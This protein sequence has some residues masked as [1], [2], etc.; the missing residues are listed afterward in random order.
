MVDRALVLGVKRITLFYP[1][2]DILLKIDNKTRTQALNLCV[3]L[4]NYAYNKGLVVDFATEDA[5]RADFDFLVEVGQALSCFVDTFLICYTVGCLQPNWSHKLVKDFIHATGCK[6]GVHYHNDLGLALQNT[7]QGIFA[8]ARVVSGTFTGI[9]ERAGNAALEEVL[10]MLKQEHNIVVNGIDY[11]KVAEVCFLIKKVFR[12]KPAR[13]LS[14]ASFFTETGI[15]VH[16]LLKDTK[17]YILFPH[18]QPIIW[19]GKY[20][21]ASNFKWLFEREIKKQPL[22]RR[23][24]QAHARSD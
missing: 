7:I 1:V 15:H 14:R 19:F 4:C 9:G 23:T 5:T 16:R 17:S 21:G 2:S 11:K 13:P 12:Y 6:V 3:K 24:I 20:S 8:G 18:K 10:T 22:F